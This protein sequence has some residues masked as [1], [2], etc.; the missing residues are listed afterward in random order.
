MEIASSTYPHQSREGLPRINIFHLYKHWG[1][2]GTLETPKLVLLCDTYV[3]LDI[4]TFI[5]A[6]MQFSLAEAKYLSSNKVEATYFYNYSIRTLQTYGNAKIIFR[7][8]P[9][10]N[11]Q[12]VLLNGRYYFQVVR[13]LCR[14]HVLHHCCTRC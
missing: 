9:T 7:T 8:K 11:L 5:N 3:W 1:F 10:L 14:S 2:T 12:N 13:E 4:A 6:R